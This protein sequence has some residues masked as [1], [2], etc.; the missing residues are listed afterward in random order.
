MSSLRN[1]SS[2]GRRT[3][4]PSSQFLTL[5]HS[6]ARRFRYCCP[7]AGLSLTLIPNAGSPSSRN[8][9]TAPAPMPI[10]STHI[11]VGF[12]SAASNSAITAPHNCM[13]S[14][15]RHIRSESVI[16]LPLRLQST[17][18]SDPKRA[19]SRPHIIGPNFVASTSRLIALSPN[20][21]LMTVSSSPRG[22]SPS[23]RIRNVLDSSP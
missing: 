15:L 2:R 16:A 20:S 5:Y 9:S 17:E 1:L 19:T 4:R 6:S 10:E 14:K 11:S 8:L 13:I 18:A 3:S 12:S 21:A 7:S 22:K 23:T